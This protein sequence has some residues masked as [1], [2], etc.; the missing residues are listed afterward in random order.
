MTWVL[1]V[2]WASGA[3]PASTAI[4]FGNADLCRAAKTAIVADL[5]KSGTGAV[6]FSADCY[7][8]TTKGT[9]P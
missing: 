7:I 9:S 5:T 3:S 4:W 6:V 2:L 8:Q 1:I